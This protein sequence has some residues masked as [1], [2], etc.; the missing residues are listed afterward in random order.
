MEEVKRTRETRTEV[1][2]TMA[3]KHNLDRI[4]N[5]E[6]LIKGERDRTLRG[7]VWKE[8]LFFSC[9]GNKWPCRH[10]SL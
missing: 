4:K 7:G 5:N 8:G 2:R 6:V 3:S 10:L 1:T 9:I